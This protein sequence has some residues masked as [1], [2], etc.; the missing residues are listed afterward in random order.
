MEVE[1]QIK[2][3]SRKVSGQT[4]LILQYLLFIYLQLFRNFFQIISLGSTDLI[5]K[6][7]NQNKCWNCYISFHLF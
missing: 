2:N 5:G 4:I 7:N 3:K 1:K 6:L